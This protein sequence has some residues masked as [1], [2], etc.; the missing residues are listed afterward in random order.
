MV[1][2]IA[3]A[4]LVVSSQVTDVTVYNDRAQVVRTAEAK[5]EQGINTLVFEN[6]PEAVDPRGI[7]VDGSGMATVLDVRF[8]TENFTDIPKEAWKNL[9]D[10]QTELV[11]NEKVF[12]QKIGRFNESKKFLKKISEKVTHTPQQEEGEVHLNPDSWNKM[13]ELYISKSADYDD[14]IR[15]AELELKKIRVALKKIQADIRDTGADTRKKRRV[16]EV[17]LEVLEA[18]K[19]ELKLTYIVHGPKW[20]PTYDIRVATGSREMEV[21]YFALIQQNTGESWDHISLKLSTANPGLGGQH[22]ELDSWR[23]KLFQPASRSKSWGSVGNGVN[24][25]SSKLSANNRFESGDSLYGGDTLLLNVPLDRAVRLPMET[26]RTQVARQGASVVFSVK[27]ACEIASDNVEHRVAVSTV[28]LPSIFRYSS[29]PK[30]DPHAY[31]KAKATNTADHPFL[32]GK[33]NVFLDGS[34][35]ATSTMKLVAPAEEFWVFLGADESMKVEHKLIKKYRS[36]EGLTGRNVRHTYEY[37]MTVKNTHGVPEE[38]VVFDQLPI[39]GSEDLKVK[40]IE[41]KYSKDTDFL[42]IDDE[43]LISW[44]QT[45]EAGQEWAVPFSFYVEAPKGM[46]IDGLE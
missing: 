34:F 36:K 10:K 28:K 42:K 16:V 4:V 15:L 37:L 24:F 35:V 46:K 45:L 6:L 9:Y 1:G 14:G 5:L 22:P 25:D 43:Q 21:K 41:P 32:A 33:A 8:K 29:I 38:V 26:R 44:I 39:S 7:Q 27:G 40:L 30:V 17:D 31:L 11:E 3:V 12:L 2:F 20:V 19:A 23:I 13:L 18:G